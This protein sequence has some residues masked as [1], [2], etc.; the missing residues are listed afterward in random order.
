MEGS[1]CPDFQALFSRIT[2]PADISHAHAESLNIH[3]VESCRIEHLLPAAYLP[4]LP[5]VPAS[6]AA[7][8]LPDKNRQATTSSR[9]DDFEARL[10][11]LRID[12][13]L[14]FRSLTS[15]LPKGTKPLRL[16]HLRKFWVGLENMSPYWDCSLDQ[17]TETC[18]SPAGNE[19]KDA[20]RVCLD[21]GIPTNEDQRFLPVENLVASSEEVNVVEAAASHSK[22]S[23][24]VDIP[25]SGRS[26]TANPDPKVQV[27][28]KGRRTSTGRDMPDQFRADAVRGL[29][30]CAAHPFQSTL[31][32]PRHMPIVRFNKLNVPV[33][34]TAAVYR[35]SRDRTKAREGRHEGPFLAL[36]I[37]SDTDFAL[38]D[39]E[40]ATAKARQDLMREIGGVLQLA[41]ERRREGRTEIKPGQGMWYTTQPR[42]GGGPGGEV[43]SDLPNA[44][45][46]PTPPA[47]DHTEKI[48]SKYR[49]RRPPAALQ[50]K[51]LRCGSGF[52]DNRTDY[53]AI[54]KHPSSPYDEVS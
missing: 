36:Q 37:R 29:V 23:A 20:K 38:P 42:W 45:P 26:V 53:K 17:F 15:R 32:P 19:E 31:A 50:W 49:R 39:G 28:Y 34:Q 25:P 48:E 35:V 14:A 13:D 9:Q 40:L 52:W 3:L 22:H 6:D 24:S 46:G 44:I 51:E 12:N 5:H 27:R 43:Q 33:R 10:S 1:S 4:D 47:K 11:E 54:G 41:Q 8:K 21:S 18:D 2:K 16:L 30:E 7:S